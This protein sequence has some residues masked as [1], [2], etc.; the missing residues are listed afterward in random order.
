MTPGP[1]R[2]EKFGETRYV[3]LAVAAFRAALADAGIEADQ[4]NRLVVASTHARAAKA[5]I[6]KLG[7][8]AA[9]VTDDLAGTVGNPGAAQPALLLSAALEQ[10]GRLAVILPDPRNRSVKGESATRRASFVK[11]NLAPFP[12]DPGWDEVKRRWDADG[13]GPWTC[14]AGR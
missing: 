13:H 10:A 8:D 9:T 7:V 3:P 4:V 12:G 2:E 11:A 14:L 6:K 1:S 5:A